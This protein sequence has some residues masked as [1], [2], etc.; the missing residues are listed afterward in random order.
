MS[1]PK[2]DKI[3]IKGSADNWCCP[4]CYGYFSHEGTGA[5]TCPN[6]NQNLL[7]TVEHDPVSVTCAIE[8]ERET[9]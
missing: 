1:A 9:L 2:F 4:A 7:L 6:C 5:T 8:N 3:R